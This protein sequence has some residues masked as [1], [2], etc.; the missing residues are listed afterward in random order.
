MTRNGDMGSLSVLSSGRGSSLLKICNRMSILVKNLSLATDFSESLVEGRIKPLCRD[1][2][3][4]QPP[5]IWY[6]IAIKGISVGNEKYQ[7]EKI[8]LGKEPG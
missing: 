6:K 7:W 4:T 3:M 1:S 2:P 5:K 8:I